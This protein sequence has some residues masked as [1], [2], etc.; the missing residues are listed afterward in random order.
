MLDFTT[1]AGGRAVERLR[2]ERVIWLISI[3]S[4][5]V[6]VP[7]PLW[8]VWEESGFLFYTQPKAVRLKHFTQHP[9]VALH[10]NADPIGNDVI[11]FYGDVALDPGAPPA[12]MHA[13]YLSKYK[14]GIREL[15]MM[16]DMYG[17]LYSV[18]FR[19]TPRS[20]RGSNIGGIDEI[21][22]NY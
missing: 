5:G 8:F 16:P 4:A 12:H 21:H 13:G 7:N 9:Q 14:E 10:F 15:G 1:K 17:K 6:P 3:S 20:F 19:V 18:A 2:D 22:D 11:V